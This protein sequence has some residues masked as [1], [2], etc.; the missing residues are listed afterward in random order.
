MTPREAAQTF[1]TACAK[2]DWDEAGKFDQ[3]L[4]DNIKKY[5]GGLELVHLGEP[6]KPKLYG[7]WIV[8]YE[9]KFKGGEVKKGNLALRNDN[10][11]KRY[12]VDGGL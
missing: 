1:F 12:V 7:G 10:P 5:L 11:A 9:I 6:V 8:P 3:P 4:T 2:E